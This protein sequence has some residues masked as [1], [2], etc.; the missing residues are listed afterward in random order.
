[1]L[2]ARARL[3]LVRGFRRKRCKATPTAPGSAVD[4]QRSSACPG[5]LHSLS[6][7]IMQRHRIMRLWLT[8][9]GLSFL[10]CSV[11]YSEQR[12][13]EIPG[14]NP[15]DRIAHAQ[16]VASA[17]ASSD[18]KNQIQRRFPA[19]LPEQL[20]GLQIRWNRMAGAEIKEGQTE[21]FDIISVQCKITLK[22]RNPSSVEIL[23]F[24]K[25]LLEAEVNRRFGKAA[26]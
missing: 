7:S 26:A 21:P 12:S 25:S 24:C 5:Q 19:M 15:E 18:Y 22:K 17:V 9:V 23:E 10:A 3:S 8:V 13:V 6:I 14:E 1:M 2:Y 11:T 16:A 4:R 20:A